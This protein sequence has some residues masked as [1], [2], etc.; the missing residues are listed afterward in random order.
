MHDSH[1]LAVHFRYDILRQPGLAEKGEPLLRL[2]TRHTR[3]D[4]RRQIR[5]HLRVLRRSDGKRAQAARIDL[6]QR[7]N[8][9]RERKV[10]LSRH[11]CNDARPGT[12][13]GNMDDVRMRRGLEQLSGQVR[14]RT[15]AARTVG[16]RAS[17]SFRE[18]DQFLHRFRRHR[19]VRD[20]HERRGSDKSDRQQVLDRVVAELAIKAL[21]NDDRAGRRKK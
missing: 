16:E 9:R 8:H 15:A 21:V 5:Q 13:E 6:R 10:D 18:R 4:H 1:R 11:H 2:K 7:Q 14:R 17:T 12:F 3:F 19:R 20:E